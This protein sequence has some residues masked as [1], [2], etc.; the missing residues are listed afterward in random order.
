VLEQVTPVVEDSLSLSDVRAR[1][2]KLQNQDE[3][4]KRVPVPA[5]DI[6]QKVRAYVER[7]PMPSIGDIRDLHSLIVCSATLRASPRPCACLLSSTTRTD[8]MRGRD[9]DS[10]SKARREIDVLGTPLML[11]DFVAGS[12][13]TLCRV[14]VVGAILG[15]IS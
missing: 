12:L 14:L 5:S 11:A 13:A 6:D 15:L 10:K 1:I 3:V 9:R 4:L 8:P 2:K 7:L